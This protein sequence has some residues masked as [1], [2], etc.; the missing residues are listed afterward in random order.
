VNFFEHQHK[1]RRQTGLLVCYFLVAITL[2]VAVI[3]VAIY[4]AFSF[5]EPTI[6][7]SLDE[8]IASRYWLWVS[9]G[10]VGI[11]L[12]GSVRRYFQLS[13]G[14]KAVAQMVGARRLKMS[15]SDPHER[16]FVNVVEEMSI[17][18]GTPVPVLYVMDDEQAINAFVA[19]YRVNQAVMVV[20]RGTLETLSRDE[21]QGVVGHEY[22]H[23]LNG[24][25]RLNVRLIAT[26]A[27]L[28]ALGQVGGF[29]LRGLSFSGHRSRS[30]L[31]LSGN[32]SGSSNS[33]GGNSVA[34]V[35]VI[36]VILFVVG[37]IG[38]FFGRL[39]K[40]A[41][42]RQR[43]YLADASAVQFT[44]NPEGIASA[45]WKI[46]NG[47]SR[48]ENSH[49]EDMSH[50]CFSSAL[51]FS[52]LLA[53]HPPLDR[54]IKAIDP[55]FNAKMIAR[56]NKDNLSSTRPRSS[57]TPQGA[58][59]QALG[60]AG[61][62]NSSGVETTAERVAA[63]IGNP[64]DAHF[65]YAHALHD[66]L[67]VA[68][69]DAAHSEEHCRLVVYALILKNT[70]HEAM[71]VALAMVKAHD[72]DDS[73]ELV[74]HLLGQMNQLSAQTRLPI[75]DIVLPELKVLS[76]VNRNKFLGTVKALIQ[77]D[78]RFT[79]F[80]FVLLM[81]LTE[82]LRDD[83]DKADVIKFHKSDQVINEIRILLT[84]LAMSGRTKETDGR[85]AFQRVMKY[86]TGVQFEMAGKSELKPDRLAEVFE[87][88]SYLSPLVKQSVITACADCVVHDGR[89][90][91]AEAELLRATSLSLDCPMPPII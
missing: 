55:H 8:W 62:G 50:M 71:E 49:A 11:V 85:D 18:S 4:F 64:T 61:A 30:R 39:I 5:A 47:T 53:T 19:G 1:A 15:T 26:L 87:K 72:G 43:E 84:V 76:A 13:G 2:T 88:L 28:L 79:L 36:A 10:V 37:Y 46:Q 90:L 38:L 69:L 7:P 52:S 24:D 6:A 16:Q 80:E 74:R 67:P 70:E 27:G 54:R 77:S 83:A 66:A 73:V 29:M 91:P 22:S 86:F 57:P 40:A 45:L 82:H 65:E 17:A 51:N 44:R 75:I 9:L 78:K 63:S 33:K 59:E 20:T 23:V 58:P 31:S 25:M 3:N 34:V 12:A 42:S 21:L 32:R 89:V 14:G 41:V 60:F 81:I 56:R 68:I 48:L 35:L